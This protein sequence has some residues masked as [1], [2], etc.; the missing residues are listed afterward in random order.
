[1]FTPELTESDKSDLCDQKLVDCPVDEF[2]KV[3]EKK[4]ESSDSDVEN[5]GD[6]VNSKSWIFYFL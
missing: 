3:A 4:Q 1:M 5:V 2:K 6:T